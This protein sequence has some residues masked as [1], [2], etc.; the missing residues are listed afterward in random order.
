MVTNKITLNK[1]DLEN[2]IE[3]LIQG[4]I[5]QEVINFIYIE[6]IPH[7]TLPDYL[8]IKEI[9]EETLREELVEYYLEIGYLEIIMMEMFNRVGRKYSKRITKMEDWFLKSSWKESEENE[10]A[11]W[12]VNLLYNHKE[13]REE[14]MDRPIKDKK[15]IKEFVKYFLFNYGWTLSELDVTYK[16]KD[17]L[18]K[19]KKVNCT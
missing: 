9:A 17:T 6:N 12:M 4:A 2:R 8:L 11:E 5:N 14:L 1:K 19:A 13:A 18:H 16:K 3:E 7:I 10:F 15:R